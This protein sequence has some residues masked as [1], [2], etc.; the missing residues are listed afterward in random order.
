MLKMLSLALIVAAGLAFHHV[1]LDFLTEYLDGAPDFIERK[2]AK[3]CYP[4]I[5]LAIIWCIKS[6]K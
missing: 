6:V 3:L 2:V 5:V 1:F 4:A